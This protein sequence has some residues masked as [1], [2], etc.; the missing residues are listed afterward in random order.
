MPKQTSN[1]TPKLT[2]RRKKKSHTGKPPS[3]FPPPRHLHSARRER[4]SETAGSCIGSSCWFCSRVHG[5][6]GCSIKQGI[7]GECP[8]HDS[9]G[10]GWFVEVFVPFFGWPMTEPSF[11]WPTTE[12]T[13]MI[14]PMG[15]LCFRSERSIKRI[16][17]SSLSQFSRCGIVF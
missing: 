1:K 4:S 11:G 9:G 10:G 15:V 3:R 13:M 17:S 16:E 8:T 2:E 7:H 12:E 5:R 14:Q 6:T